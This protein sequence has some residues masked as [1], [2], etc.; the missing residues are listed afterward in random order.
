MRVP[1][2]FGGLLACLAAAASTPPVERR[3]WDRSLLSE[4][5]IVT[6]YGNPRS[7]RMG[8]LGQLPPGPMTDALAK[9][10]ARWQKADPNVR[11]W[12]GLELVT[13]VA[14]GRPEFDGRYRKRVSYKL[15]QEVR[16]WA[17]KRGWVLVLDVQLGR[18]TVAREIEYL[19]PF[20]EKSDVHLA[21]DPEFHM[22]KGIKPG[23]F[24]GGSDAEDVNVAIIKLAE[25]VEKK[26][27]PGKLLLVHRFTDDML[28]RYSKIRLDPRVE[29]AVVMDG[30][31]DPL[32]KRHY[33]RREISRQRVQYGGIKLFYKNDKPLMTTRDVLTLD[34]VPRVIIYQ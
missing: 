2:L 18:S 17:R 14:S 6:Y 27:L 9:E 32:S 31:G 15:I 3:P 7:A 11:V 24:I 25:I 19:R 20:L 33:Y 4:H 23:Q 10:A 21:I 12:P 13:V 22:R 16:S 29:V 1:A 5:R 8:I 28:K 26:H 34:P 30:F